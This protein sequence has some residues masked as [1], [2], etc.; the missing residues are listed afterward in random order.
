MIRLLKCEHLKTRGRYIWLTAAAITAFALVW[1]LHGSYNDFMLDNGWMMF[2]YQL[3]IIN[4][5]FLPLLASIVASRLADIEHKGLMFKQLGASAPMGALYDA[6]LLY[7]LAIVFA[8]L[9]IM[10]TGIVAGG[11]A[12]GFRSE[13]PL[14]YY[15]VFFMFTL[16]V[17]AVIYILQHTL[18]LLFK[19]QAVPFFIGITGEFL[20]IVLLFLPQLPLLRKFI[21]WGYYGVLSFVGMFGWSRETRYDNAYFEIMN[22]DWTFF[23]VL[24]AAGVLIYIIGKKIFCRKEI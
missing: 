12:V 16:S 13:L 11:H 8:S 2:L 22:I 4:V 5:L 10:Y 21:P 24:L 3:P 19:N 6:K 20:G 17:T 14:K 7:G 15:A 9:F 23:I 1:A 18:S